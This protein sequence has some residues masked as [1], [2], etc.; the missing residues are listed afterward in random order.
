MAAQRKK[1]RSLFDFQSSNRAQAT[2]T[3]VSPHW[4]TMEVRPGY[5]FDILA[6]HLTLTV[7]VA[8]YN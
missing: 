7:C 2:L 8:A 6:F 3:R 1:G 5:L 4:S